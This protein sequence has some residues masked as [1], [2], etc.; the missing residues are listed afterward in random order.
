ME[1]LL[2][3]G[4]V[5]LS[6]GAGGVLAS[7]FR[8][9]VIP[10]YMLIGLLL[11]PHGLSLIHPCPIVDGFATIGLVLLLLFIGL[12]FSLKQLLSSYRGITYSGTIDLI[13]NMSAGMLIGYLAGL[14][15][16]GILFIAGIVYISSSGIVAKA[17][18][19]FKRLA[20]PEAEVILGIM[21]FEDLVMAVYLA[22]LI[23]IVSA[24]ASTKVG[25]VAIAIVLI[26]LFLILTALVSRRFSHLISRAIDISSDELFLLTVLGGALLFSVL[27]SRF[28][29]SEAVGAFLF[30][31]LL[32]E[33]EQA[34]R[35]KEK[36]LPIKD[37]FASFFFFSFGLII[38]P[39]MLVMLAPLL[40]I[41]VG[42][43]LASKLIG[44][45]AA[46]HAR[47]LSRRASLATGMGITPRGEFSLV[48]SQMAVASGLSYIIA[49]FTAGFVLLTSI[50]GIVLTKYSDN[51]YSALSGLNDRLRARLSR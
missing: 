1:N 13:V 35:V 8:Q 28:G 45:I 29:I 3:V 27:A 33:T 16:Y 47:G 23:S 4:L 49:P 37:V 38:D 17:L 11:G 46:G 48:L 24:H 12:E 22:L 15:I 32:S 6:L 39:A 30:G 50:L 10:A 9:S 5:L 18:V 20:N 31:L 2:I 51:M 40:A 42:I 41:A 19:D 25:G 26:L 7:R 21:V 36:L 44:G 34:E 43:G 14:E